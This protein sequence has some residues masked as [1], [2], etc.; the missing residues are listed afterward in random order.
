[1]QANKLDL[2]LKIT[3]ANL[4]EK[5]YCGSPVCACVNIMIFSLGG[6]NGPRPVLF[7]FFD[8][9]FSGGVGTDRFFVLFFACYLLLLYQCTARQKTKVI[10]PPEGGA[11]LEIYLQ[12]EIS[13]T[14]F[15]LAGGRKKNRLFLLSESVWG[16]SARWGR[17]LG[18]NR[19]I[20]VCCHTPKYS[21]YRDIN[22]SRGKTD[23]QSCGLSGGY[24]SRASRRKHTHTHARALTLTTQPEKMSINRY[25]H[26]N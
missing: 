2:A 14:L 1:M 24:I 8:L 20:T 3:A 11:K 26:L 19:G 13:H 5:K 6:L 18:G 15:H 16:K 10:W 23:R 21:A 9:F 22:R 7:V 17:F 25:D 12:S 4:Q